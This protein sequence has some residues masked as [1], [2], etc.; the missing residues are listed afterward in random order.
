MPKRLSL[1]C[2]LA[3]ITGVAGCGSKP[4]PVTAPAPTQAT[5]PRS[6]YQRLG[7]YDA[8]AAVTDEFIGRMLADSTTAAYFAN[9]DDAGK[10]RV[11]QMVVDQLCAATGGPCLY[12]GASMPVAHKDLGIAE[13]DWNTAVGMLV[14]TLYK[15]KVPPQEQQEVL[16]FV[17]G[18]KDEIVEK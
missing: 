16:A 18:L 15:F 6:L 2:L 10:Q 4:A 7:G 5:Q 1:V 11:R 12:V 13:R 17:Q 8:L 9:T 3:M 14:A